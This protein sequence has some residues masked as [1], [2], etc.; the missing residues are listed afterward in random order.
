MSLTKKPQLCITECDPGIE[1]MLANCGC[2]MRWKSM[3]SDKWDP[4]DWVTPTGASGEGSSNF[5][6]QVGLEHGS[7]IGG[8]MMKEVCL[9]GCPCVRSPWETGEV[10][11]GGCNLPKTLGAW[12]GTSLL[13]LLGGI[14]SFRR[15]LAGLN[16][17]KRDSLFSSGKEKQRWRRR[18]ACL[19]SVSASSAAW[20][21]GAVPGRNYSLVD[22]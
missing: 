15:S 22:R 13:G 11:A 16:W 4:V 9:V 6:A 18:A 12:L 1:E 7:W 3:R 21:Q 17:G 5:C 2:W 8:V 10:C 19:T 20:S 14:W